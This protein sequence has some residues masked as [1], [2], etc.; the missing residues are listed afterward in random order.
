MRMNIEEFGERAY[1]RT[2]SKLMTLYHTIRWE[3]STVTS[4]QHYTIYHL[5]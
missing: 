4:L 2:L 3:H 1:E 5:H